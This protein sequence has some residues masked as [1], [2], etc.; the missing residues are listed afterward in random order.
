MSAASETKNHAAIETGGAVRGST[1]ILELLEMY[2][3]GRAL[4]LMN[5]LCW[6]CAH[7]S[8]RAREPLSLAAKRHGNPV[9]ATIRCFRSLQSGGPSPEAIENA[10]PIAKQSKDPLSAW[11]K[12][13]K[14][15]AEIR[16]TK[17]PK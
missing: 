11:L 1:T 14:R 5:Q 8:A 2:P 17:K 10:Q 15:F 9:R 7:C 13:A 12:S 16:S 4:E 3:D 6:P